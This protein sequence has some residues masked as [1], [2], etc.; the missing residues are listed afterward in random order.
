MS[1][2][3]DSTQVNLRWQRTELWLPDVLDGR[4]PVPFLAPYLQWSD[5]QDD[6]LSVLHAYRH[7]VSFRTVADCVSRV[8][9]V[10][11]IEHLLLFF[12][13]RKSHISF[14]WKSLRQFSNDDDFNRKLWKVKDLPGL[15]GGETLAEA[16]LTFSGMS[17]R[18]TV[19]SSAADRKT[20]LE[21]W[22]PR[23]HMGPSMWPLTRMLHAAFFSP[24]SMISAFLVPTRIFPLR[25]QRVK[26]VKC[27]KPNI[28]LQINYRLN[29]TGSLYAEHD[30]PFL[31]IQSGRSLWSGQSPDGRPDSVLIP[32]PRALER[33]LPLTCR[34]NTQSRRMHA[35]IWI[36]AWPQQWN[37]TLTVF[38]CP[39]WR[40]G[41]PS[42][43]CTW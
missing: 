30:V 31:C 41:R 20:S 27:P 15:L 35:I 5:Q 36:L 17:H 29:F 39:L 25:P 4:T 14:D 34:V 24:T 21:G 16:S 8:A 32:G 11:F 37:V 2:F 18:R 42:V 6:E 23:P 40:W 10:H 1:V 38:P 13:T 7:H 43:W 28:S 33:P 26:Y 12:P 3:F 22:V 9:Q 19:P